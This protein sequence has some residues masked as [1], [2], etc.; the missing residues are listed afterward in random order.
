[1][2]GTPVVAPENGTI[3][4]AGNGNLSPYVG[5]GP[6]FVI[7]QGDQSGRYHLLAHLDQISAAMAPLGAQVTAGAQIGTTSSANHT[8]WEVRDK[9]VP[10]FASGE[11]N[12]DNNIDPIAW[13]AS[14][15]ALMP[16]LLAGGAAL[17]IYLIMRRTS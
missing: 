7:V 16:M 10:D 3:V 14:G 2:Q 17:L 12:I 9:M 4:M 8:H 13:L 15:K 5:Y 1:V 11:T 6:W